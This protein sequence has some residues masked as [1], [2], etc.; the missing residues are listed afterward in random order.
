MKEKRHRNRNKI[1]IYAAIFV[2]FATKAV[3][4]ELVSDL[5]T[6][7]FLAALRRFFSRRGFSSDIY[8][9]KGINFM[10][11]RNETNYMV[12]KNFCYLMNIMNWLNKHSRT[13]ILHG[14]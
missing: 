4:I 3:H 10:G 6:E 14:T 7:A 12:Y 5:T 1:K 9:D 13:I 8:S 11:A 2:C